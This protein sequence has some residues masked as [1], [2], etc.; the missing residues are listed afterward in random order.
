MTACVARL[1]GRP[2][3]KFAADSKSLRRL[4]YLLSGISARKGSRNCKDRDPRG[5][6]QRCQWFSSTLSDLTLVVTVKSAACVTIRA[7]ERPDVMN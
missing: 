4:C 7:R 5:Q 1:G 6:R 3:N 2:P